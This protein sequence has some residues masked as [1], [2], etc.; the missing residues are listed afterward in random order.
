VC[1]RLRGLRL[2]R[3]WRRG[4]LCWHIRLHVRF[5]TNRPRRHAEWWTR[6]FCRQGLPGTSSCHSCARRADPWGGLRQWTGRNGNTSIHR[7]R[8]RRMARRRRQR[9]MY[10]TA[11]QRWAER[12]KLGNTVFSIRSSS[13]FGSGGGFARLRRCTSRGFRRRWFSLGNR[14]SGGSKWPQWRMK[15]RSNRRHSFLRGRYLGSL[16]LRRGFR[17]GS[18]HA[19]VSI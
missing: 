19:L 11:T 15:A 7:S 3:L 1:R 13:S 10:C 18:G 12:L 5:R 8:R 17:C 2:R 14:A 9:R 16:L 6:R 4:A